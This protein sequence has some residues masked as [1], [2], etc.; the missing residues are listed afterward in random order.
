MSQPL[1]HDPYAALRIPNFRWFVAS[2]MAMTVATQIQAVVVAW[3]IYDLTHDPLSLGLIGLAEAVPFIGVALFAGHVADRVNRLRISLAALV[4]LFLCSVALLAFTLSPGIISAGRIWPIYL[5]IFLSGIARSFLQPARSALGAELVP[6][7]LYPNAVTWRSSTWQLAEV[8]G[9]AIGGLVYGFGSATAAYGTDAAIMAVGVFSLARMR[10]SPVA[11]EVSKES[12]RESLA[13]GIRFVRGQPVIL[14]ALTLDL[15][16]VLF[17]GAVA[18]LPVFAAEILHVGP[19]GLGVLRAAPA[20]GAVLM[21]LV[22]AHLPPLRQAGKALL[23]SVAV[24]GLSIIGFGLSR[25]FL[26]SIALLAVSGMSDTVS[27]VIRSTLLQVLTP[28]HLLG[29]V[30][31][32]NAIFIGSSNEIGAFE[33]GSAARLIGTVPSVVLGGLATLV[34]VAVTAVKVPELRRLKQIV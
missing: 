20:V 4:A 5:V 9:P 2:L 24:F 30:S 3:Q 29:R 6:R 16:S 7:A 13:T 17:G 18:L 28:D 32:V 31:S 21:S 33:S 1:Q 25:D 19:E 34:V 11:N 23:V 22:L 14:G 8:V 12:F 15:F 10:H 26:L 27:V